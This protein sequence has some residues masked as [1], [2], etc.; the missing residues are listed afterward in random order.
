M[1]K[2]TRF[3]S[4]KSLK[5]SQKADPVERSVSEKQTAELAAFFQQLN[6]K[7]VKDKRGENTHPK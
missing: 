5:S 7:L 6:E 1:S 2:L 3:S 4:F